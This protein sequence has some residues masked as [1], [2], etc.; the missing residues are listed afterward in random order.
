MA[1]RTGRQRPSQALASISQ[2]RDREVRVC[3][4]CAREA[5]ISGYE[6]TAESLRKG[7]VRCVVS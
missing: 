6:R 2:G 3:A 5:F 4:A 7:N 1:R